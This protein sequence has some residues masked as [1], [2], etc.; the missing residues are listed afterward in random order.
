M[1]RKHGVG[2]VGGV[3]VGAASVVWAQSASAGQPVNWQLGFQE[4]AT[5]V[6]E[7]L[8]DF[9]NLLLVI[10]FGITAFVLLLLAYVLIRFRRSNNPIPSRT[11]H[12]TLVEV[13]WTVFPVIILIVIAVPSFKLLYYMDRTPEVELTVKAIG[14]Q[15]YWTYEYPDHEITFEALLVPEDELRPGQLRLLETDNRVVLPINTKVRLLFTADDVLHAWAV[16]AFGIK[17]DAVPG[18]TNE[19]WVEVTREGVYYGQC[20]ELCGVNHGFMPIAVEAVSKE[21]F[22]AWLAEAKVKFAREVAPARWQ[23]ARARADERD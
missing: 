3:A 5:P 22:A 20:S 9:H 19:A 10:I 21:R 2:G 7:R 16:P 6:M 13:V 15:W 14:Q 8:N 11:T 18:R 12:N 4:A 17:I 23:I 1:L